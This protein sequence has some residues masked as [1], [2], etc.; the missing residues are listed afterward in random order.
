[1]IVQMQTSILFNSSFGPK[2]KKNIF[3]E[4]GFPPSSFANLS[5]L[6]CLAVTKNIKA[7][8]IL[9]ITKHKLKRDF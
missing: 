3:Y 2:I 1:M 7:T 6:Y 5:F 9:D 4:R 8:I